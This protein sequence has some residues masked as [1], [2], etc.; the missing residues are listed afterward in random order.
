MFLFNNPTLPSHLYSPYFIH[1]HTLYHLPCYVVLY[2]TLYYNVVTYTA[3]N[4][5]CT[6]VHYTPLHCVALYHTLLHCTLLYCTKVYYTMLY[7]TT[8]YYT[9]HYFILYDTKPSLHYSAL[10]LFFSSRCSGCS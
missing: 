6:A 4:L 9:L 8:L 7:S 5:C 10:R 3:L 1:S 2:C